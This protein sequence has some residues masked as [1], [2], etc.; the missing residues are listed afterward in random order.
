MSFFQNIFFCCERPE[1]QKEFDNNDQD[2]KTR[3]N[4]K[5]TPSS[6]MNYKEEINKSLNKEKY[7][8]KSV[9]SRKS[10]SF[11]ISSKNSKSN[12]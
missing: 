7:D 12:K 3:A 2:L 4:S 8:D 6:G 5:G 10:Y 1:D 11:I 9:G